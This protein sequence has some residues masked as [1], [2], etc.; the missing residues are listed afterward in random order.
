MP[1]ALGMAVPRLLPLLSVF[2]FAAIGCHGEEGARTFGDEV[3][4]RGV[5]WTASSVV[6]D[7]SSAR[8]PGRSRCA[9]LCP[10]DDRRRRSD[11]SRDA[12]V[13]E[14]GVDVEFSGLGSRLVSVDVDIGLGVA[15]GSLRVY[16]LEEGEGIEIA[17]YDV[18][19]QQR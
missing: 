17:D 13:E 3:H 9:S 12:V 7:S 15:P 10:A 5:M 18:F 19:Q 4:S 6:A 16:A 1:D 8:S 2:L 11:G 14:C